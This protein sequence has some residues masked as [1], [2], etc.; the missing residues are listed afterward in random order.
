MPATW[1]GDLMIWAHGYVDPSEPVAIPEDQLVLP[2]GTSLI[3]LATGLN[4]AFAT[5]SYRYNGLAAPWAVEDVVQLVGI[6]EAAHGPTN[7]NFLVG[8][9]EGGFVTAL[10]LENYPQVFD[11]GVAACGPVGDFG[12]QLAYFADFRVIFNYFFPG[13]LPGGTVIP[14]EVIDNWDS[15]YVPQI[16]AAI[17]AEPQK[18]AQLL[19]VT[20]APTDPNDSSTIADTV[21]GILSYN[22]HAT[23]DTLAKLGGNPYDNTAR[24]YTG[25]AD[26]VALNAGVERVSQDLGPVLFLNYFFKTTG[27]LDSPLVTM[28]TL[29]DPIVPA[30]H[31]DIYNWK[32]QLAGGFLTHVNVPVD[33]YGHCQFEAAEA[34][35][36]LIIMEFLVAINGG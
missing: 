19:A 21:L 2:D 31:E 22:V 32:V 7:N 12:Y 9:S 36:A 20:G 1:N 35:L 24:Y 23:N 18:T 26:D 8:A 25:S 15:T 17:A 5:T 29:R 6:F 10:A 30:W 11:G 14:Q 3:D 4:F 27:Q 16:E 33:R 13:I 34:Y 28:H